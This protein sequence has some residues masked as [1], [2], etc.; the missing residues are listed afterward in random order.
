MAS[1]VIQRCTAD[2]RAVRRCAADA[3]AA[4][5][6]VTCGDCPPGFFATVSG[7]NLGPIDVSPPGYFATETYEGINGVWSFGYSRTVQDTSVLACYFGEVIVGAYH[8]RL[9]DLQGN[10]LQSTNH[11]VYGATWI[12][13]YQQYSWKWVAAGGFRIADQPGGYTIQ[14][15]DDL[16]KVHCYDPRPKWKIVR[17]N[18]SDVWMEVAPWT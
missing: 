15:S 12:A 5:R 17:L 9:W 11:N 13:K 6:C 8:Y 10:L 2:P 7:W 4:K 1:T 3:R 14:A 16:Q 18:G